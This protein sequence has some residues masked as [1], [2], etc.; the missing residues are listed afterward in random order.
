[1]TPDLASSAPPGPPGLILASGSPY[2]A[3]LLRRLNLAFTC[4]TPNVDETPR[5]GEGARG[6][7]RRLARA[8]AQAVS[9]R[10]PASLVVGSDQVA[11]ARGQVLGKPGTLERAAAQL[12]SLAGHEA[13]FETAICLTRAE[14]GLLLEAC[15]PTTVAFR[16]LSEAEISAYVAAEPALDC[17]GSCKCEGLGIVLFERMQSED[18]TALIGLPLITLCS[19]LH[20]AGLNPLA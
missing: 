5:P 1:M 6:L 12:R 20:Q 16:T 9:I 13:L 14:D 3:E 17:A 18:P 10:H 19:L 11:T 8:K 7:S 2:R 15:V 4:I